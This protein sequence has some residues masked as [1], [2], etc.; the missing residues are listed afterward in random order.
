[1]PKFNDLDLNNGNWKKYEDIL[2]DSLWII[3]ERDKSGKHSNFYHG[4]FVPQIPY[5][6]IKRYTKKGGWVLDLFLG[7]GTT[8]IE[9]EKLERNIIGIDLKEEL[10][11]RAK[12]LIASDK[13]QKHFGLGDSGSEETKKD[14]QK[15]LKHHKKTGVDLV[16]LHPPYFDIIKFSEDKK[17]LSN[18]GNLQDFLNMFHNVL[19]NSFE[20]LKSGGYM[21]VV[22]GDK[23]ANSEWIPLGFQCMNEAQKVGFKLK[24]IIVKNMEGNRGKIGSGGIWRYRALNSDYYIFKHEYI[25]I[26]KK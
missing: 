26:F 6:L 17:D 22:I 7:S 20:L 14:I 24:S 18:A 23:Y 1:M 12:E 10:V 3:N 2:T 8:A 21:G 13:I 19:Q 25:L 5:Q 16:L 4:N 15:I 9:C 11:A